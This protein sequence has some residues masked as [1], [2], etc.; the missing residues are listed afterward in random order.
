MNDCR[1]RRT[2]PPPPPPPNFFS[3][4]NLKVMQMFRQTALTDGGTARARYTRFK[5]SEDAKQSRGV[6][7]GGGGG[8]DSHAPISAHLQAP[9][10]LAFVCRKAA[11]S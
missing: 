8:F 5:I 7:G 11:C 1:V 9:S 10:A 2:V 4:P 6:G 3:L